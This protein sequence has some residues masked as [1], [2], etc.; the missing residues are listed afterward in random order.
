MALK[1]DWKKAIGFG[2][3]IWMLM[4]VIV[5]AFLAFNLYESVWVQVVIALIS[6]MIAFV[7]AGHA[8]PVD[9]VAALSYGLV[10]LAV[11]LFLDA[12]ITARFN[13]DIFCSSW[14]L[15]FGYCLILLAPLF[16][17]KIKKLV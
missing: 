8:K 2:V 7:L 15:W 17:L 12:I 14:S 13:P 3:A 1:L 11:N 10:W 4:F 16:R 9:N 6:G 5:S